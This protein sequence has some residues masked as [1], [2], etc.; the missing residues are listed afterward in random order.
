MNMAKVQFTFRYRE[1]IPYVLLFNSEKATALAA[2]HPS[3]YSAPM[4][5]QS[6]RYC[7]VI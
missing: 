3:A 6:F 7:R 5:F 2:I 1:S 4:H